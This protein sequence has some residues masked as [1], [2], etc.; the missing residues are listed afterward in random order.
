METATLEL[1]IH[2]FLAQ[3]RIAV[4]GV[5]RNK[6]HHPAGNLIYQRLKKTGHDVF[7]VNPH[8]EL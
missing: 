4:A 8:A 1:K 6:G 5:S 2:D 3:P 7:A